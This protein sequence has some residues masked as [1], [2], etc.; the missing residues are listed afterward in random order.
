MYI[1]NKNLCTNCFEEKSEE[2]KFCTS[3]GYTDGAES[4][5]T[6]ALPVGT[7]LLGQYIVGRTL[8]KGGFGVTYLAYDSKEDKKVAV[9]EYL[10]DT[11]THRNKGD[12]LV[13]T[14][15]GDKE[16]AFKKG[17]ERF[18]EEA[19]TVSRFN[20]HPGLIW[21]H[22]FFYE[23]N[24]AYFVMEFL[25]GTDLKTH[26]AQNGGKLSE[27]QVLDIVVPLIDS[28]IVVHSVGVL[29]RDI[30]PD[31]IYMTGD[32]KIKLLDFGAARQVLGEASKSLS[33]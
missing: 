23:N 9:K 27:R 18:Y 20:G 26:I 28:L 19:Q 5:Y 12:T 31:N 29:H 17:A 22:K 30:S 15:A 14:I 1:N 32:G 8:G 16:D 4:S 25:E 6:T 3:C 7:V 11:I 24:T 21:V 33:V 10:P 2:T 13:S